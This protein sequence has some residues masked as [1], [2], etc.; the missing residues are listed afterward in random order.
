MQAIKRPKPFLKW[1]GGKSK[2]S[3]QIQSLFP[4]PLEFNSYYEPFLGSG[5][6]YFRVSP[7]SGRLNDK[8]TTLIDIY[9]TLRD[10][11]E[12]LISELQKL[13]D[14]YHSLSDIDEKKDY[15]LARRAE[16][17]SLKKS[18]VRKSA[19]FI[20]LNKTGFNGM[21]RENSRGEYNIPFGKH[22]RPLICDSENL[23]RVSDDL[24]GIDIT[25]TSY[26][27]AVK[28]AKKGD[29]V[30]LDPPYY[31]IS[32]TS[33]FTEYQAGGFTVD[34]QAKLRDIFVELAKRGCYVVMSNS[35]CEE[36]R[37]LY[38]GYEIIEIEVARAINSKIGKRG[39]IKEYLITNFEKK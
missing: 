9:I 18:S 1:A 10:N 12:A 24:Q 27:S 16:F 33:K 8:N 7:R 23:R 14:S 37:D 25:S 6:M 17:N 20:F 13:Q 39:K 15:Y 22:E 38:A 36:V 30:Y 5:A 11:P 3:D 28:D 21:Y 34:D 2:I 31:P 35:A 19:L 26:E 4:S 29:L 32:E